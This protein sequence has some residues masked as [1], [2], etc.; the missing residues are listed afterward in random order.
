MPRVSG[1]FSARKLPAARAP[2]AKRM[3]T[4]LVM[5]TNDWKMLMPRTA[6]SLH[7][8]F[9]K[10]KAVVLWR[11]DRKRGLGLGL[12]LIRVEKCYTV[13]WFLDHKLQLTTSRTHSNWEEINN[14]TCIDN[15]SVWATVMMIV[16][17]YFFEKNVLELT[18][19]FVLVSVAHNSLYVSHIILWANL[20]SALAFVEIIKVYNFSSFVDQQI[21]RWSTENL[22]FKI[23]DLTWYC[24]LWGNYNNSICIHICSG[25]AKSIGS[26]NKISPK[27]KMFHK[28]NSLMK[29]ESQHEKLGVS[30]SEHSARAPLKPSIYVWK[31]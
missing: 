27:Q 3:G 4:A 13:L 5:P 18:L 8:A 30:D 29:W 1:S 26:K 22:C 12:W 19:H 20:K 6:A 9:K 31:C 2:E 16:T 14:C 17:G 7:N 28:S 21:H 25:W 10:P 24:N 15:T 23:S 11:E